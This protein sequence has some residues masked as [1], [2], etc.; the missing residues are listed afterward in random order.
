MILYI[1]DTFL[2]VLWAEPAWT[3]PGTSRQEKLFKLTSTAS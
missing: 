2:N 1:G 3:C